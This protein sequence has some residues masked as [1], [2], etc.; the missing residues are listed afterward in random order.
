MHVIKDMLLSRQDIYQHFVNVAKKINLPLWELVSIATD[1]APSMI[2]K[3]NGFLAL[4]QNDEDFPD[5]STVHC[6]IHQNAL[7]AKV[8]NMADVMN[9][10]TKIV[11]SV[12]ARSLRRRLF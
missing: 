7:C 10:A 1:G 3:N 5:F 9:I 6:V 2:G 12:R 4:C 11:N 8:L